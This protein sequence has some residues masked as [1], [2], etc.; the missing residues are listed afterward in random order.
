MK[1]LLLTTVL[2]LAALPAMAWDKTQ[3]QHQGQSQHQAAYGGAGGSATGGNATSTSAGGNAAAA[4]GTGGNGGNGGSGGSVSV[5]G[6]GNN[7]GGF[8]IALPSLFSGSSC[9]GSLS[10][11]FVSVG[12]GGGGG[13]G[14]EFTE[15]K[16]MREANALLQLGYRQAAVNELCQIDRV[17]QAFGGRCPTIDVVVAAP[18]PV[19]V[20]LPCPPPG[21]LHDG[22]CRFDTWPTPP[23]HVVKAA[24]P[25]CVCVT[26]VDG[27]V[28]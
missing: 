2:S 1:R 22:D 8:G 28:P 9:S 10:L 20:P 25:P 18:P 19:F 14:W 11:G 5:S 3:S 7:G 23:N 15:C 12:G 4:G 27:W 6:V 26:V 24:A 21:R 16:I 13:G 17:R